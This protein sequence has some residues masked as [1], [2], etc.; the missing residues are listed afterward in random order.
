GTVHNG[1]IGIGGEIT[2]APGTV[3]T[4][5]A[6]VS[7][8]HVTINGDVTGDLIAAAGNVEL[9]GH[10]G[11]DVQIKTTKLVLHPGTQ[12][13]GDFTYETQDDDFRVPEGVTINGKVVREPWDS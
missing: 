12:I 1:L 5:D 11:G 10:V 6:V 13:D 3:I 7:G 4:N 8:G 9:S 2:I